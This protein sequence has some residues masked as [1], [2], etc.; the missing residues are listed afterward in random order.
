MKE[1]VSEFMNQCTKRSRLEIIKRGTNDG[2]TASLK[3][4]VNRD[5]Q[6][7]T[8]LAD[9][10]GRRHCNQLRQFIVKIE[11]VHDQIEGAAFGSND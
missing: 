2:E 3:T 6:T 9:L 10:A 11:C 4:N 7:Q 1:Y 5:G 8:A